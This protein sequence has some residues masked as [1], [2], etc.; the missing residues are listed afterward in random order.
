MHEMN[1]RNGTIGLPAP[2]P[3]AVGAAKGAASA[4]A[5]R[6]ATPPIVRVE[7]LT[8]EYRMGDYVVRALRGVD[9][10]VQRREFVAVMGPSGSGKSTFMNIIGCLDRATSGEFWLDGER[11]G[12]LSRDELAA[13]RN[14]KIGFVF[15]GFNLLPGQ[16]ALGNVMLPMLYAGIPAAERRDRAMRALEL[17]GIG[18]RAHHRPS[19]LSGGQQQRVAIARSLV[20][21]PALI[22]ADEP[23]GN[24]D[25]RTSV[26]LMAILQRLNDAGITI[27]M[28]THEPDIAAFSARNVLF[29]D[30]KV[31][32]DLQVPLR[33]RAEAVLAT[34]PLVGDELEGAPA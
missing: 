26:E 4:L 29:R 20:N 24:L 2:Y 6:A 17:V 21:D 15:Q 10:T 34:M 16:T 5:A 3:D 25:S 28:V 1:S 8:R 14:R 12:A 18:D 31:I 30:G 23:T 33:R 11:I 22:L 27:V 9:L 13:I 7:G 32:R 19:E